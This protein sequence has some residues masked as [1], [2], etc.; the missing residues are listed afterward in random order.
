MTISTYVMSFPCFD[1][2]TATPLS[3]YVLPIFNAYFFFLDHSRLKC[4][5]CP[6]AS[7]HALLA[8]TNHWTITY[9]AVLSHL[10]FFF[11]FLSC[12]L[13]SFNCTGVNGLS[14]RLRSYSLEGSGLVL[15]LLLPFLLYTLCALLLLNSHIEKFISNDRWQFSLGKFRK[16]KGWLGGMDLRWFIHTLSLGYFGDG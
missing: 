8:S 11:S 14:R 16:K 13:V 3:S 6:A 15:C 5:L 9:P 7:K 4:V 1:L 10:T 12:K 2:V